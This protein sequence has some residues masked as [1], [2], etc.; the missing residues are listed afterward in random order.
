[1]SHVEDIGVP[2]PGNPVNVIER[3]GE[4][5]VIILSRSREQSRSMYLRGTVR[6]KDRRVFTIQPY[7]WAWSFRVE[8][9]DEIERG[10][11]EWDATDEVPA[12]VYSSIAEALRN[13]RLPY[14]GV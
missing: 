7:D 5:N 10:T 3:L 6:V 8:L 11:D 13:L 9:L 4:M 14:G 1:M 2:T 12:P